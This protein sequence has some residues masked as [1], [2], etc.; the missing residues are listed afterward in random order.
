MLTRTASNVSA[1]L[2]HNQRQTNQRAELTALQRALELTPI[3]RAV[4]IFSDSSYA[5]NCATTWSKTWVKNNWMTSSRKPVENRDIVEEIVRIM[6]E[7]A[8]VGAG[9]ELKWLKGHA[10]DAGNTAADALAVNG[11]RMGKELRLKVARDAIDGL[12]A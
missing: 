10:S 6:D 3:D 8:R 9:T 5:I 12:T 2:P 1:P 7:R 4:T 11:A